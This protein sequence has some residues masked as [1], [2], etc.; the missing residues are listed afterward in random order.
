[1]AKSNPFEFNLFRAIEVFVAVVETRHVTQAAEMLGITQSAASQQLQSLERALGVQVIDRSTRPAQ[2]TKSGIALH[3]R[4]MTILG[5]VESLRAEVRQIG[6]VPLPLLR[7]AMLASIATTLCPVLAGLARDTFNIPELILTAGLS[8]DHQNLLRSRKIDLAITSDN[9]SEI[10]GLARYPIM[11]EQF[12]LVVPKGCTGPLDD[13]EELAKTLP[14]VRFTREAVVGMRTDQHLSR[15]R[16]NLPRFI[17]GDRASIVM[18]P[19]AAGMGFTLLTPTLLLDG[20]AEGMEIDVHPLPFAGFYREITLV[21]REREL[22]S[23]PEAFAAAS[24]QTLAAAIETR[25]PDLPASSF[26]LS[27]EDD[28]AATGA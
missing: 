20:L 12:L 13:L 5:E 2:L 6:S 21:T 26:H 22:G 9:L 1:M 3:K 24:A 15:V 27:T 16:V 17:E 8:S 25:L 19:V 4:A 23:Q 28:L 7:I 10:E 14:M 11:R 18:A